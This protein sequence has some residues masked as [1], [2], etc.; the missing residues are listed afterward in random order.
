MKKIC[1]K[2]D[3]DKDKEKIIANV[4]DKFKNKPPQSMAKTMG[5]N[6]HEEIE[7]GRIKMKAENWIEIK[8]EL[9]ILAL[10][11]KGSTREEFPADLANLEDYVYEQ[12]MNHKRRK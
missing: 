5:D 6:V 1:L 7:K 2:K 11:L 10:A 12:I 8:K 9:K 3:K 4:I